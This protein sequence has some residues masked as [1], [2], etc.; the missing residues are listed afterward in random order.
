MKKRK[1][2]YIPATR[3]S[4]EK[5][6]EQLDAERIQYYRFRLECIRTSDLSEDQKRIQSSFIHS[7]IAYIEHMRERN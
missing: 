7:H 5:I 4:R 1:I 6:L 2:I 3:V